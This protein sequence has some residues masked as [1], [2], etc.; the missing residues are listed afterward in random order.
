MTAKKWLRN[1]LD[2]L[3]GYYHV[4]HLLTVGIGNNLIYIGF[5]CVISLVFWGDIGLE[6]GDN[7]IRD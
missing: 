7:A 2:K 5:Y 3:G 4:F 1:F 6:Y